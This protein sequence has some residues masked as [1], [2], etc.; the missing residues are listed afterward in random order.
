MGN[1]TSKNGKRPRVGLQGYMGALFALLVFTTGAALAVIGY[2]MVVNLTNSSVEEQVDSLTTIVKKELIHA[3]RQ[4]VRAFLSGLSVGRLPKCET[5]EERRDYIYILTA[6]IESYDAVGGFFI[7]Y[8]DGSFFLVRQW[9]SLEAEGAPDAPP[10]TKFVGVHISRDNGVVLSERLFFDIHRNLLKRRLDDV[11]PLF[12]P[13]ESVWFKEAMQANG[14][15]IET[16]PN[17]LRGIL[18]PGIIFAQKSTD[19]RA[20]VAVEVSLSQLSNTLKRELPTENSHLALLRLDGRIIASTQDITTLRINEHRVRI[21]DQE[22]FSPIL[23]KGIEAYKEGQRGHDIIIN[24]GERDWEIFIEELALSGQTQNAMLLAIPRDDL[25]VDRLLFLRYAALGVAGI[26]LFSAPLIWL[27]SRR[28]SSPLQSLA[29]MSGSIHQLLSPEYG[30]DVSSDVVEIS[31]LAESMRDLQSSVRNILDITQ[32]ISSERNFDLLLQHVL[33]ET[34]L[35][36][37]ANGS[38]LALMGDKKEDAGKR[39][40]AAVYAYWVRGEEERFKKVQVTNDEHELAYV[41]YLAL[42]HDKAG[43]GSVHRGDGYSRCSFLVPGFDDPEVLRLDAVYVPLHDRRGEYLGAL[44]LFKTI[45]SG[46]AGFQPGE[47]AFIEAFAGTVAVALE[48]NHLFKAQSELRDALIHILAGAIDAKSPYTGG[49]CQRVPVLFQMILEAACE[50]KEGLFKD[51]TLDEDGWEE[52]KLAGWLHDCGKVT[53]PEYVVD[54]ATKLETIYDRI[55]EVRTRFEVLK[56]DAEISCLRAMLDGVDEQTAQQDLQKMQQTL[57][58]EF[59]FVASCNVGGESMDDATL[60]RLCRIGKRTWVRTLDKRLGVSRDE[61]ARMS[62][63]EN[64]E[65]P[66]VEELLMDCPEH[67]IERGEHDKLPA[68]PSWGFKISPPRALYNRG[69][70]YNLSIRRGTLTEEERYKINDHIMQT[71]IMLHAVPLP[72]HLRNVPE[73]AGGHHETMDGRGYPRR[74]T[75]EDMSLSARIMAVADIFEAL[76]ACDR[77]YRSSNTLSEALQIMDE[78]K[79][80]NHIDPD[81]YAIFLKADIPRRYGVQFL[82]AQQNDL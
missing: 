56:R 19:G 32:T 58:D 1:V 50:S 36:T 15:Q 2:R 68:D 45:K 79:K 55:H 6:F 80:Q 4:P 13:R 24:D 22:E 40:P 54:K 26:L 44:E 62:S 49:H 74:L 34:L 11:A 3:V 21:R 64:T 35:V 63:G 38:L 52:A 65:P 12:D 53:T 25:M 51:F 57:D 17:L 72:K 29:T 71:I 82:S 61:L 67:I 43:R 39:V 42:A 28:I 27:T 7:G 78:F 46:D 9:S 8:G 41:S 37:K 81:V 73:I 23:Q 16:V 66:I 14:K 76:T 33:R 31:S 60:E 70:L 59:A 47:V 48:N 20:V 18:D 77:P 30:Q 75:R 5:F 10:G 69:E